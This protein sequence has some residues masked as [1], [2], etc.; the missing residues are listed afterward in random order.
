MSDV[1]NEVRETHPQANI[2]EAM[3]ELAGLFP[4]FAESSDQQIRE[5]KLEFAGRPLELCVAALRRYHRHKDDLY[6]RLALFL[7]HM[8]ATLKERAPSPADVSR[9]QMDAYRTRA[10]D[11]QRLFDWVRS[12]PVQER[13]RLHH[14]AAHEISAGRVDL[15]RKW[16]GRDPSTSPGLAALMKAVA[17]STPQLMKA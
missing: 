9:R 7:Q 10:P 11:Y 1:F 5:W 6:P 2:R 16:M 4:G 13:S 3:Y 8:N 17:D 14:Q 15:M 12:L